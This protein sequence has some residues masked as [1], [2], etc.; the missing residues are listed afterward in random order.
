[1]EI[2]RE[3]KLSLRPEQAPGLLDAE[4]LRAALQ[5]EGRCR[6]VVS[7]YHDTKHHTLR[8]AGAALRVR[9]SG[10][11]I[12]QTL[13][14]AAAGPAGLQNC[15]EWTVMLPDAQP[16][17][18]AFDATVLSRF[19]HRGRRLRLQPLFTTN[20]ERTTCL[21]RY[22]QTHLEM[23][24]DQGHIQCHVGAL[25]TTPISEVE[26]ELIDGPP[27]GLYDLALELL[28]EIDLRQ[29]TPS[30]A[31]R[32]YALA[33]PALGP[34]AVKARDV[35]LSG[36][37][38][39]GDAFQSIADEALRHLL[40]NDQATLRGQPEAIH[41]TRV[42]IRRIRAALGAFRAVLPRDQCRAFNCEFRALQN[43]LSPARDWYV[44]RSESLPEVAAGLGHGRRKE[45]KKLVCSQERAGVDRAVETLKSRDYARTL[46]QFQRWLLTVTSEPNENLSGALMPLARRVLSDSRKSFLKDG[47]P[48]QRMSAKERH[49]LRKRG[50][51][52]RYATEFFAGLWQGPDV[53]RY[54]KRMTRLQDPL[55]RANDAVVERQLVASVQ[56]GLLRAS[57]AKRVEAWSHGRERQHLRTGQP[58]WK[59][60]QK[61]PPFWR[62]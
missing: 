59:K 47:R 35:K 54:L 19:K 26:L 2:E 58:V 41:Q 61:V 14:F 15:E 45:L 37:M 53:D 36:S 22:G 62:G 49:A 40:W 10:E 48:L 44:F 1:M 9:T 60:A 5:G 34:N 27:A 52:A 18:Q 43:Q 6:R 3:L 55:G 31:E 51:K 50:K 57:T 13:K 11:E 28:A 20:V 38:S 33:R 16:A 30:K 12:E 23:A 7:T 21:L 4:P 8:K 24:L 29:L 56:P 32:G 46:L 42:A 17:L 39:V 25:S